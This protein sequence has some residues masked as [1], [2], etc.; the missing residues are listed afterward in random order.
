MKSPIYILLLFFI[1]LVFNSCEDEIKLE[2]PLSDPKMVIHGVISP[3]NKIKLDVRKSISVM[4]RTNIDWDNQQ[5]DNANFKLFKNNQFI[6]DLTADT[7]NKLIYK[8]NYSD[9]NEGETY[10]LSGNSADYPSIFASVT[11]PYKPNCNVTDFSYS[12]ID[13]YSYETNFTINISDNQSEENYYTLAV[14]GRLYPNNNFY[15]T[16]IPENSDP[17]IKL[18]YNTYFFNDKLFN[19]NTK[20]IKINYI[21]YTVLSTLHPTDTL[22]VEC[23]SL[24]KDYYNYMI[25]ADRQRINEK[26]FYAE[27]VLI[28]SNIEGG[29]GILGAYNNKIITMVLQY[30]GK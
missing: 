14:L 11:I 5:I 19:G 4:N 13:N 20:T 15:E 12:K 10:I 3:E 28:K 26:D 16:E 21:E 23:R 1:C 29:Y 27:P 25:A 18:I 9:F 2:I 8:L 24:N 7:T 17:S 22:W 6:G 30:N